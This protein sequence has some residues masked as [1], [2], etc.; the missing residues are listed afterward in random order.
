MSAT[1]SSRCRRS[2]CSGHTS[3]RSQSTSSGL[4]NDSGFRSIPQRQTTSGNRV[5]MDSAEVISQRKRTSLDR[6]PGSLFHG[7]LHI[8]ALQKRTASEVS[9]E[10]DTT[11]CQ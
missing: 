7:Q 4:A 6:L 1:R 11:C 2:V 3:L 5:G 10:T 8:V 9:E